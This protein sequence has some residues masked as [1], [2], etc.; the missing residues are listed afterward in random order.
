MKTLYYIAVVPPEPIASEI[1]DFK[2]YAGDHFGSYHALR[3]PAHITLIPPFHWE[4]AEIQTIKST[5][6]AFAAA[7]DPFEVT[8]ENFDCFEPQVVFVAIQPSEAL[9]LLRNN[10]QEYLKTECNLRS[11]DKRHQFNP[12]T[13]ISFRYSEES[14]FLEAWSYFSKQAYKATFAVNRIILFRHQ[15]EI[16][17]EIDGDFKFEA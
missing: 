14:Q 11:K 6:K 15:R 10:L 17:W 8:Y 7:Q 3:S 13:T 9:K 16:G 1:K 5:L 2:I 12:H 4:E